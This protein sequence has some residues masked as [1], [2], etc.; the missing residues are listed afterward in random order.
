MHLP[1]F[2]LHCDLLS[3]LAKIPG[4]SPSN[5]N[6][7]ACALPWLRKGNVHLQVLAIYTDV[8]PGSMDLALKQAE[9][10]QSLIEEKTGA[11]TAFQAQSWKSSD[12]IAAL[13]SIENAAGLGEENASWEAIERQ[14]DKILSKVGRLAY[15]SLTHH[16]ENRFGGGNYTKGIGLKD[17]GRRLLDLLIEKI[18]PSIFPIVP[19]S[20]QKEF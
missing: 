16:T 7:I 13:A 12:Q 10:F 19:T 11:F 14:L 2:D 18:S 6:D 4:A 5:E 17:E 1:I 20:W 3:Y 8:R 15:V 9:I